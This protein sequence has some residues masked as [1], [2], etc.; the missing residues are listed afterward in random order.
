M[1]NIIVSIILFIQPALAA[2]TVN[3]KSCRKV[4]KQ[5]KQVESQ[6]RQGY[7]LK[8]GEQLMNRLRKLKKQRYACHKARLPTK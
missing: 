7:S 5:I 8:K 3:E 4:A 2:K 1:R 6:M